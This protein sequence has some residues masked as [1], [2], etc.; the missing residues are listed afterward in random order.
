MKDKHCR[1]M[2]WGVSQVAEFETLSS[3]P[4]TPPHPEKQKYCRNIGD[5]R[6]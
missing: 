3:N 1:N 4:T 2:G 6:R 5:Y